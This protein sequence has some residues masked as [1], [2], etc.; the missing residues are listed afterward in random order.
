VE[1]F[2]TYSIAKVLINTVDNNSK[3]DNYSFKIPVVH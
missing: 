2:P 3:S 1:Y